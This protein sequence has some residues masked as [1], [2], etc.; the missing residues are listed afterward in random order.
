[1]LEATKGAYPALAR[2]ALLLAIQKGSLTPEQ[3]RV[4]RDLL[5]DMG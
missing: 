4:L 1:M 3:A 2:L 5:F